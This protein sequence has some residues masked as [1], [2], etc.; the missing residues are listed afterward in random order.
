MRKLVFFLITI[1]LPTLS[2]AI[3]VNRAD[4]EALPPLTGDDKVVGEVIPYKGGRQSPGVE[5]GMTAYDYQANGNAKRHK[6]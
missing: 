4:L 1:I 2:F 3:V 6:P 5:I